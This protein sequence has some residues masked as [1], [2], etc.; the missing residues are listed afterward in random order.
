MKPQERRKERRD[1]TRVGLYV[2]FHC[3]A[4]LQLHEEKQDAEGN[5]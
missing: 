1:T 5:T 3:V 2:G 4:R